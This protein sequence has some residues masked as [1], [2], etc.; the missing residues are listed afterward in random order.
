MGNGGYR[1]GAE[2]WWRIRLSGGAPVA[3]VA[4]RCAQCQGKPGSQRNALMHQEFTCYD[5]PPILKF[6]SYNRRAIQGVP[7]LTGDGSQ[8]DAHLDHTDPD[9]RLDDRHTPV[10]SGG[11]AFAIAFAVI[12]ALL[13]GLLAGL[14]I[15]FM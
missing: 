10:A 8:F 7:P 9:P 3:T 14:G 11:R 15:G 12:T 1:W 2:R 13:V 6:S 4:E 5:R